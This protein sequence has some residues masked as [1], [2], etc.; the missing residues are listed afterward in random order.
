M[1]SKISRYRNLPDVDRRRTRAAVRS[2]RRTLR[3]LPDGD[4]RPSGTRSTQGDRLDQLAY[5]Y[6]GQPR[7][8]W[9]I[10]DAN[11]EFLSPLDARR[12]RTPWL[13]PASRAARLAA[14]SLR[15]R[16][17]PRRW[18]PRREW[19]AVRFVDDVRLVARAADDRRP[20]AHRAT[21]SATSSQSMVTYNTLDRRPG[22]A[23]VD[24]VGG[25][26]RAG[27]AGRPRPGR[28]AHRH[29][30]GRDRLSH[31]DGDRYLQDRDRRRGDRRPLRAISS[32]WRSSWTRSWPACSG[33]RVPLLL[34]PDGT[35]RYLDDERFARVEAGG[36][37]RPGS[38]DDMEELITGYIT[39]VRP[40][41]DPDP[42]AVQRSRSGAWTASVLMDREDKLKDWPN[43]KDS[44]IADRDLQH[45]RPDTRGRR[46]RGRARRGGLD[47]HPAR[48]RHAVPASG[49]RCATAS[50]ATS[51]ATTGY[52]RRPAVDAEPQPRAGGALRRRDQR[53][54][55]RARGQRADARR[56][57]RCS[58]STGSTRRCCDASADSGDQTAL[59]A[60]GARTSSRPVIAPGLVVVGQTVTTGRAEMTALC[61]GLF[62]QRRVVRHR[63]GRGGRQSSTAT[64]SSRAA[65]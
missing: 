47:D 59:G 62:H 35:W 40:V 12:P 26:F 1:F 54:P 15:G 9:R 25:R 52:F 20:A 43:K 65:R 5:T 27:G 53:E 17:S 29:P 7:K 49:W 2:P 44:D 30:T 48:D 19:R 57:S 32:A 42:D 18:R 22:R 13:R 56:T 28:P 46:H 58:R 24:A 50:S 34:E 23:R 4:R 33:L 64:C 39:H 21:S 45:V 31:G 36:H 55:V 60:T 14:C 6:Y 61:Q 63:R 41:F 16:R 3:L 10:C 37:H 11:P 8:W 51:T 38:E